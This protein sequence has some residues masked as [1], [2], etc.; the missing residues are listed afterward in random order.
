M[1]FYSSLGALYFLCHSNLYSGSS[2][3]FSLSFL[4]PGGG[5]YMKFTLSL[6]LLSLLS[7]ALKGNNKI[8]R[9]QSSLQNSREIFAQEK[10]KQLQLILLLILLVVVKILFLLILLSQLILLL[11]V[12]LCFLFSH[13][14]LIVKQRKIF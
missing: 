7:K 5:S 6:S 10:P 14:Y 11:F 8:N 3:S 1:D 2:S 12:S 9:V 4:A 13:P